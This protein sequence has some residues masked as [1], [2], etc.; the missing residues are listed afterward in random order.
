MTMTRTTI[1][2]TWNTPRNTYWWYLSDVDGNN[3]TDVD[4]N[5]ILVDNGDHT[6]KINTINTTWT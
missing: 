2:T 6:A 1:T 4:S 5:N 3:I